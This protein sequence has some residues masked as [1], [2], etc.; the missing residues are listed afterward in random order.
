MSLFSI[1]KRIF[2]A[3]AVRTCIVAVCAAFLSLAIPAALSAQTTP[4]ANGTVRG[5]VM[6]PDAAIIP[7]AAIT[8]TPASGK[9]VTGT[10]GS[11]GTYR[12]AAPAGTYTMTVSMPG[13]AT[14]SKPG[15]KITAGQS[16]TSDIKLII[17]DQETVV[18]VTS[19]AATVSVDADS[20]ASSTIIKGADLEALSDDPDELSAELT[21][22]AGPSAG[23]SG[24]QIYVDGFTG[25]QL[26]PKSSIREIRINQNPFSAEYDKLGFGRIEVF[27]KPGTDKFHGSLSVQGNDNVLNTSNPFLGATGSQPPYYTFFLLGN[28]TGPVTKTSSFSLGGSDRTIQQNVI[29]DPTGFYSTSATATA[30]CAPGTVTGC[31]NFGFP[32]SARAVFQPQ[33]RRDITPRFDLAL[34]KKNVLT[35]RY[36]YEGGNTQNSGGGGNSLQSTFTNV[37][38]SENTIQISD[39]QTFNAKVVNETRFEWQRDN[40]NS[41][42]VSNAPTLSVQGSFT[43]GGA[44]SES[45]NTVNT[46]IEAQNYTSVA[47]SKHFIR[48][49]GRL[50]TTSE[51]STNVP[52]PGGSFTYNYLLDPC[53]DPTVTNKPSSCVTPNSTPCLGANAGASSYQCGIASQFRIT[54]VQQPTVSARETDL[55]LYAEDDWKMR[56]NLTFSYGL[57]YEAENKVS[58]HDMAPR[59]S[60]AYGIPRANGKA[61]MTVLR[62][63][64]GIFYDRFALSDFL[65][66]VAEQPG[67]QSSLTVTNPTCQPGVCNG[68][69]GGA[70]GKLT[71]YNL[72]PNLRSSYIMQS[73]VG[74]DQ[75]LG[76]IG[77]ISFNYLP[78]LGNHEFLTRLTATPTLFNYQFQSEGVFREQQLF[79][80][81]N[82]RTRVTTLFGYYA[83]NI[84]NSNTS[85]S[86]FIPTSTNPRVDYGR[87]T[88]AQRNLVAVGASYNAPYKI[89]LAPFLVAHSGTPYNITTGVDNNGDSVYNDRPAFTN[90]SSASCS[91]ASTF[92]SPAAGTAYSEIPINYCTGP[93]A[94]TF[95]LRVYRVFGFGPK[96]V[97]AA[98]SGSQGG[99][100]GGPGGGG[101]H[102]GGGGGRGGIAPGMGGGGPGGGRG[103]G[104]MGGN[105]GRRFNV[106]LGAQAQNLFNVIPYA[107]PTA[108]SALTS[109]QFGKLTQLA[110]RPFSTP[111]AVRTIQLQLTFNF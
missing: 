94:F 92:T 59:L 82:I 64:F 10:S 43:S 30:P 29:V 80:N 39:T 108:T 18:N 19:D 89:S 45:A 12:M 33:Q 102:S 48:F 32:A 106:T 36:Q 111:N 67:V 90:G 42:A 2:D 66:T 51:S 69:S 56:S 22:L 21:A 105:S 85:G 78:S 52:N 88:F 62:L 31:G 70:T 63:G 104:G 9:P 17:G 3:R 26:P 97:T 44:G 72:A 49:G 4:T 25:G 83:L 37:S 71:S 98:S 103:G 13:F 11:D 109:T 100:Q 16:I 74:V 101:N 60:L 47:L 93:A 34:G 41:S 28:V 107:A 81:A 65:T 55:G 53:S 95:N 6:D 23:P 57:R 75:Q 87:A 99:G 20:N 27:T 77:T 1:R 76:K 24:G 40:T 35:A 14:T 84:A 38:N 91:N 54:T 46:H 58:S 73:A 61:P 79:V 7:G 8:L 110:G 86:S 50:R 96:L 68:S 15:L 5:T